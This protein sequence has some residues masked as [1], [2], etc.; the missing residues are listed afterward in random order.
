MVV[1]LDHYVVCHGHH[2]QQQPFAVPQYSLKENGI[3]KKWWF[4]HQV[5]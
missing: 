5:Y 4:E 1:L 3:Q 2:E